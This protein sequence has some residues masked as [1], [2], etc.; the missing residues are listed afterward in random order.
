MKNGEGT[1]YVWNETIVNRGANTIGTCLLDFIRYELNGTENNLADIVF[2]SDNCSEQNKNKQNKGDP[3]HSVV[4]CE[5]NWYSE[6][7]RS[8]YHL[9]GYQLAKQKGKPYTVKEMSTKDL[10]NLKDLIKDIGT[11]FNMD[12]ISKKVLWNDIK[13][14]LPNSKG[15]YNLNLEAR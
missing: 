3:M 8:M 10:F 2:Y 5:K 13:Y 9:N 12:V 15:D 11:N 1:C 6:V 4:K 14:R 7:A